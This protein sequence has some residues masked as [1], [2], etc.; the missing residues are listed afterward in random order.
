MARYYYYYYIV[1]CSVQFEINIFD[2]TD[3][4]ESFIRYFRG[5]S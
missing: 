5:D 3:A 2:N 1:W 4:R